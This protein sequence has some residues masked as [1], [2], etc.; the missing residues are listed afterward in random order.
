MGV[1]IIHDG[2]CVDCSEVTAVVVVEGCDR[3]IVLH[4]AGSIYCKHTE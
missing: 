1:H 4:S 3:H 2:S